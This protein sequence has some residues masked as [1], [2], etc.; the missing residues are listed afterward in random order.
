MGVYASK[1]YKKTIMILKLMQHKTN[2]ELEKISSNNKTNLMEI[3][4]KRF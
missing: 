4:S 3:F 2:E 1:M